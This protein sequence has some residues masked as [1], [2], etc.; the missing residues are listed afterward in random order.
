MTIPRCARIA[1]MAVLATLV[2]SGTGWAFVPPLTLGP[3]DFFPESEYTSNF[4]ELRRGKNI[5][6]PPPGTDLGETGH[7]A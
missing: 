3:F 7:F 5:T 6:P 1:A 4:T 2:L